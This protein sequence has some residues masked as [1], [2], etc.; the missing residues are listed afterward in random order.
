MLFQIL[1]INHLMITKP[2]ALRQ[3]AL[4][5]VGYDLRLIKNH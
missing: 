2:L 4:F 5:F 3:G 1:S